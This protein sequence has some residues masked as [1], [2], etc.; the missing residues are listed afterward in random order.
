MRVA[1]VPSWGSTSAK[2]VLIGE[3]PGRWEH[4]RGE[5]FVGPSGQLLKQW[6]DAVGLTRDA[7]YITNVLDYQPR[8]IDAVPRDEMEEAIRALHARLA[9]LDD[10]WLIVPTG[11]YALYALTG[12]G[13]VAWHQRDGRHLRPGIASWR[14]SILEYVD[15]RG[16]RIKV[17]PTVH[18]AA[19]FRTPAYAKS[20]RADWARI[21]SDVGFRDLRLP[22][23]EHA[24][25]P[26]CDEVE[27]FV[28]HALGAE[29]LAVDIET[30]VRITTET[31]VPRSET[32]CECGHNRKRH[33]EP[34][35]SI[36]DGLVGYYAPCNVNK[37]DCGNFTGRAGKPKHKRIKSEPY[38]GCIGFSYDP[39]YSLT[40]PLT[41]DYWTDPN[42]FD[43]V[44][45]AVKEL[46]ESDVE[47]V[48]QN[49]LFDAYWLATEGIRL[50]HYVWDTRAMHHMLDPL[51]A[52]DLA[53]LAS[54]FTRQPYWKDE[55][56]DPDEIAKY[57]S[58]A[59]A[60]W[61]YNGIDCCVTLE[62]FQSLRTQLDVLGRL[63]FYE[64]H[65]ADL[66]DPLLATSLHGIRINEAKRAQRWQE[67]SAELRQLESEIAEIAGE[68]LH[69]KTGLSTAKLK[70]FLYETLRLPKQ[71]AKNAKKEK[72]VSTGEIAVRR[73]MQRFPRNT[74][75]Q[76]VGRRILRHREVKQ[77]STFVKD[78]IGG[79]DGRVRCLYSPYTDTGRLTSSETPRGEGRNLQ[80][81][82]R[83]LRDIFVADNDVV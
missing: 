34:T 19:T 48:L 50:H 23:R 3:A 62:I 27:Q 76:E 55:A 66:F 80:N 69:A 43:R 82:D 10:P 52:H 68:P 57:A 26:T 36:L 47:K 14:G 16:R 25:R 12:K 22:V 79:V 73:L 6:W 45:N 30:P 7:F 11:N 21:A 1:H 40:I 46:C 58:N 64:R 39:S 29:Q 8:V 75:L 67:M 78:N 5:P 13:K 17:I 56:K 37:C 35:E 59:D 9:A 33:T 20:C 61:T 32:M 63:P 2:L 74:Q 41:R 24:I 54:L 70:K 60:L 83:T 44:W 18:P 77:L 81:I 71:Y 38:L 42:D 53:Y 31:S 4:E 51:D 65:Y 28:H 15:Q 72:V 49:G